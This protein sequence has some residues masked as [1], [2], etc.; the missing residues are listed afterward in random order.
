M[1]AG[2]YSEAGASTCSTAF[3][4]K[5]VIVLGSFVA[6]FVVWSFFNFCSRLGRDSQP[7]C[8]GCSHGQGCSWKVRRVMVWR[9]VV[10][11]LF[12]LSLILLAIFTGQGQAV[13]GVSPDLGVGIIA[14][15]VV[16]SLLV[17]FER[18]VHVVGNI[19]ILVS[20]LLL[21][22]FA[23]LAVPWVLPALEAG[24]ITVTVLAPCV[25]FSPPAR[26]TTRSM[27]SFS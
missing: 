17:F 14:V 5:A 23:G 15:A 1:A 20:V 11:A 26:F 4:L 3:Q 24:I 9:R 10:F 16:A 2:T 18:E 21:A 27:N 12:I 22:I 8:A 19:I 25:A 6:F 7:K 13:W